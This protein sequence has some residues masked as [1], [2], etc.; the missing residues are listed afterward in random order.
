MTWPREVKQFFFNKV[1]REVH[2]SR[3]DRHMNDL[4]ILFVCTGIAVKPKCGRIIM[5][6]TAFMYVHAGRR[7]ISNYKYVV[8][9]FLTT[10]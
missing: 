9:N 10:M 5:F 7:P 2:E 1:T 3:E 6:P 8:A 4:S